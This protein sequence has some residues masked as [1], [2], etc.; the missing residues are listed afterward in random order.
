MLYLTLTSFSQKRRMLSDTTA[1]AKSIA[2]C[3]SE[4][5]ASAAGALP[6]DL[7]PHG[8]AQAGGLQSSPDVRED[9]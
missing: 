8:G 1:S 9:F 4:T 3:L 6:G 2:G 7:E 5:T